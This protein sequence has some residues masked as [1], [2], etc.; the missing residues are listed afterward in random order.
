MYIFVDAKDPDDVDTYKFDFKAL[1]NGKGLT[2]FLATGETIS[3]R[4]VTVDSGI[5]KNSDSLTD[6]ST[7]ITVT[8]SG[9]TNGADY[10]IACKITTSASRTI[11][12]S[13]IVKVRTR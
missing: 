9:G 4:T 8:L 5:T 7:S 10:V 13:A 2:N 1:A 6:T 11:E 3:T 12:R